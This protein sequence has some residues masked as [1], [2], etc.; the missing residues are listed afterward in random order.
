[1]ALIFLELYILTPIRWQLFDYIITT[2]VA[3]I[4]DLQESLVI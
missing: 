1:M 4:T 2:E 3:E